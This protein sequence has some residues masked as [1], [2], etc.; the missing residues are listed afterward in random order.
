MGALGMYLRA[1]FEVVDAPGDRRLV[2]KT[3]AAEER[4]DAED[5]M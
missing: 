1:G 4:H 5:G 3:L 2:R